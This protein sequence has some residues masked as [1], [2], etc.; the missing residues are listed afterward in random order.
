MNN[1][2][3]KNKKVDLQKELVIISRVQTILE[4]ITEKINLIKVE[5]NK[6]IK[7]LKGTN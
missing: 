6:Q 2:K 1:D 3:I 7:K 5:K 4:D